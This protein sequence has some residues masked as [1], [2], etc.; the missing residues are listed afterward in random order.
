[1]VSSIYDYSSQYGLPSQYG[2]GNMYAQSGMPGNFNQSLWGYQPANTYNQSYAYNPAYNGSM[3]NFWGGLPQQ[4][5]NP[6]GTGYLGNQSLTYPFNQTYNGGINNFLGGLPQQGY[7]SY[8]TTYNPYGAFNPYGNSQYGNQSLAYPY[9]LP[10]TQDP[11]A[12]NLLGVVSNVSYQEA[13][14]ILQKFY[15]KNTRQYPGETTA[16]TWNRHLESDEKQEA[17]NFALLYPNTDVGSRLASIIQVA[18]GSLGPNRTNQNAYASWFGTYGQPLT[19]PITTQAQTQL[20]TLNLQI[21]TAQTALTAAQTA[22]NSSMTP[23]NLAAL[24]AAQ[25]KYSQLNAQLTAFN[26]LQYSPY[27]Q[28]PY[29]I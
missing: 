23:A 11:Y 12:T 1:M 9:G 10:N 17:R 6:Y 25:T 21:A 5:Y 24:Q 28:Q 22:Y 20:A 2:I 26:G 16:E 7:N 19:T 13:A 4:G 27:Y 15:D 3:G 8:G 14:R 18:E 29:Y